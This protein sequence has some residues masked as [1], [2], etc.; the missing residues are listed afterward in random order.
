LQFLQASS[1]SNFTFTFL[2]NVEAKMLVTATR[3]ATNNLMTLLLDKEK[4]RQAA[5][6]Y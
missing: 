1:R 5:C 4:S 2:G 6:G 3:Y